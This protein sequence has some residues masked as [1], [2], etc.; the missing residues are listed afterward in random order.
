MSS[1]NSTGYSTNSTFGAK[2]GHP[3]FHSTFD[4]PL[5]EIEQSHCIHLLDLIELLV[6]STINQDTYFDFVTQDELF[7]LASICIY[8]INHILKYSCV[9]NATRCSRGFKPAVCLQ[10]QNGQHMNQSMP[11]TD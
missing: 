6:Y 4:I 7:A 8:L 5:E 3:S 11:F 9:L 10:K 2:S 1:F